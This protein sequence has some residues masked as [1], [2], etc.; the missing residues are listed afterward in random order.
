ML[1]VNKGNML[2]M[3]YPFMAS[4]K[5]HIASVSGEGPWLTDHDAIDSDPGEIWQG[6]ALGLIRF[7]FDLHLPPVCSQSNPVGPRKTPL[8]VTESEWPAL[9]SPPEPAKGRNG[10][11]LS[12]SEQVMTGQPWRDD[13]HIHLHPVSGHLF[14]WM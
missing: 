12:L 5:L 10:C 14:S 9:V 8:T 11:M 1:R 6:P 3:S 7:S 2:C 4:C 13:P